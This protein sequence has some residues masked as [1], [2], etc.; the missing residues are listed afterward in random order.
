MI[1]G[2]RRITDYDI[3]QHRDNLMVLA[4]R[5]VPSCCRHTPQLLSNQLYYLLLKLRNIRSIPFKT[6][7]R[8]L[9]TFVPAVG[10]VSGTAESIYDIE[11]VLLTADTNSIFKSIYGSRTTALSE[12]ELHIAIDTVLNRSR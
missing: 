11:D 12:E 2:N 3:L 6:K 8:I 10:R 9:S 5:S 7:Q 4:Q 1:V